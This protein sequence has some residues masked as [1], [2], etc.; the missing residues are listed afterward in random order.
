M[1][2][3]GKFGKPDFFLTFTCNPKWREITENLFAGQRTHDR[4]DLVSRVFKLKLNELLKDVTEM[5]VLGKTIAHVYVIEFQNRGLPHCHL[6]I[7]LDPNDKL[8][9]ADDIDSVISAEIPNQQEHPELFEIVRSCMIHGPCGHLN[10]NSRCMEDGACTKSFP[11]KCLASTVAEVNGYPL[12]RRRDNGHD[13]ANIEINEHV[14]HDEQGQAE[15]ALDRAADQ[16]T[17]LTAWFVLNAENHDARQYMYPDIPLYFVFNKN[18]VWKPR[19]RGH[20]KIVSRMYSVSLRAGELFYLRMLLLHT[21]G[22]T[23]FEDL[24]TVNGNAA[25]TFRDACLL[26]GL[27]QD[28]TEW[29]NT[30]Q[31]AVNFQM[32]RQLRQL[33]AVILTHCEPSGP[34]TFWT[35]YKDAMYEDYIHQ[36]NEEQAEYRLLQDIN[37]VLRQFGKSLTDY[38]LPHLDELPPVENIDVAMQAERDSQLGGQLTDE[39][40][41]LAN[42][43][44]EAVVNVANNAAQNNRL[45][46]L[47]GAGGSGKTFTYNYLIS[48]IA[49]NSTC[50]ITPVSAYAAELRQKSLFLLDEASMIPKH[51]FH[52]IDRLLQDICNNELPFGG[53]V[54]LL[55]GDFSQL[56]PVVRIGKPTE[57]V[58]MC[59]KSSPLWHLVKEFRLHRN[60]RTRPG[61]QQFAAWLLQLGKGVLPVREHEPFQGAIEVPSQCV[62]QNECIVDTLFRDLSPEIM[63]SSVVLTPTNDDSLIIN[64]QVLALLPGEEK[65]YFSADDVVCDDEEERNQY[66]VEFLNSIT[67]S[68]MPPHCLK[69]KTGAIVMLLRNININN[70]LCNGTR[71]I[72][73]RLHDNC[74]D[75]EVLTGNAIG[76]RVLIPRVQLAPS[77]TGMPFVLRRRQLPLRLSYAMTINKAQGQTLE[78]VGIL[79]RRPCF[80]HGQ[81]YVAF[82]RARAFGDVRES[83]VPSSREKYTSI[84]GIWPVCNNTDVGCTSVTYVYM[85]VSGFW[86]LNYSLWVKCKVLWLTFT[87]CTSLSD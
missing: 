32:P 29:N 40:T 52:A 79:L 25:E 30:L 11:N 77:D 54:V 20:G 21:P 18:K 70:G 63:A 33:F 23:S 71:L 50:S 60:M 17:K 26:R 73:R 43:V 6:L 78:K 66:P 9:N 42:A 34:F 86:L 44:I 19:Q 47:E 76:D 48:E 1:A 61:E 75:A 36:M 64:D 56:L 27:L 28:D 83:V 68:G 67:P 22:A 51:A 4:P 58:D 8:R 7:H 3:I 84:E 35:R 57:I 72:I 59:L 16:T 65:V 24:R 69:L 37:S 5:G 39:Q 55:G 41:A 46:Y 38:N 13:C 49:E 14:D 80:S 12:Y 45:F 53:K 82:S 10:P 15:E 2:V 74:V 85:E 87:W 62:I 31:E 81:L